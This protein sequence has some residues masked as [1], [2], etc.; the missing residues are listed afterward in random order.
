MKRRC[1]SFGSGE[2]FTQKNAK[3][4]CMGTGEAASD[5]EEAKTEQTIRK[6]S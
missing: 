5:V 2:H 6:E 1:Q 3:R 4:P